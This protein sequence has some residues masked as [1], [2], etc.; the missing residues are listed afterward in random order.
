MRVTIVA[1]V[2]TLLAGVE[3]ARAQDPIQRHGERHRAVAHLHRTLWAGRPRREQP[4]V[5]GR[6]CLALGAFQQRLRERVLPVRHRAHE[7]DRL[8]ASSG[9]GVGLHLSV[10]SGARCVHTFDVQLR[11]RS[12]PNAQTPSAR[13]ACRSASRISASPFDSIENI[14]LQSVP[15]VFTHDNAEL[16]GGREDVITTVNSIESEV[17]RSAAFISYGVT[18][19]LDVSIAIPYITADIV[20]TSDATFTASA[21]PSRRST[22]SAP[23]MTRIGDRRLFTAFGHANGLGDI[24]VRL[25][26]SDQE[27]SREAASLSGS[28][29]GCQL[30]TSETCLVQ[31]PLACSR[32]LHGQRRTARSRRTSTSDI[33]GMDRVSSAATSRRVSPKIFPTWRCTRSVRSWRSI[34]AS[35]WRS[36]CSGDTSS[37]HHAF[38]SKSFTRSTAVRCF[39][40]SRSTTGL[41]QRAQQRRRA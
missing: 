18:N 22:S 9:A 37:T 29:C 36:T 24:T 27:D 25:K 8:A 30:E 15:A 17:S 41:D 38:G 28:T 3:P 34:L 4:G 10:R 19:N 11:S 32:F 33:S 6:R 35:L 23:S 13:G 31:V 12:S 5:T 21:P 14:D 39:R 40:T 1:A 16:R 20:V 2:I 7:P 26:Q